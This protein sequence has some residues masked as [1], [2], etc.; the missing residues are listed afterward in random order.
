MWWGGEAG[1]PELENDWSKVIQQPLAEIKP[2]HR[3]QVSWSPI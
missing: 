1:G 2:E 3:A